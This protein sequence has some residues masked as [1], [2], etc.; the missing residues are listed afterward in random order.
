M[1]TTLHSF[2]L[3]QLQYALAV[4]ETLN[5]RRAA[6]RCAVAQPSLSAQVAA[7]ENALGVL[8]FE[9][10]HGG[11]TI[12][13]AGAKLLARARQI[14]AAATELTLEATTFQDPFSGSIRL[15]VIPT[16]APYVL[17]FLAPAMKAAFPRLMPNWI[18][19]RTDALVAAL[20]RG[21]LEGAILALEANLGELET[22]ILGQDPFLVCLS[23]FHRLAKG[24]SPLHVEKLKGEH[25]LLLEDGHCLRD[26]ALTAC[27]SAH[28]EELSYRTTSL[29]TLVQ[30]VASGVGITLLPRLAIATETSRAAVSLR[31][32]APP[33][34]FRT[35]ALVWRRGS[36]AD[37]LLRKLGEVAASA[38]WN[39]E[40]A[41]KSGM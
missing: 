21:E 8:L 12:T 22:A 3:R 28:L 34:P 20:Q 37:P 33:T 18:E 9:R 14:V 6:E 40:H 16:L 2:T 31:T 23:A 26:Q 11:V 19:D 5:F 35:L 24:T 27:K 4:A 10:G 39:H 30:M 38:F 17:P 25:L 32:I 15:G 36:Y 41:L 1:D 7:L 13:P 29:P